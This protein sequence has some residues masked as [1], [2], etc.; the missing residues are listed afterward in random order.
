MIYIV[1]PV[2][3][4]RLTPLQLLG[5]SA[6]LCCGLA[7][8]PAA[9]SD[10]RMDYQQSAGANKPTHS[11]LIGHGKLLLRG[12]PAEAQA[13]LLYS[14][15][16]DHIQIIDHRKRTVMNLDEEQLERLRQQSETFKPLL[17]GLGAQLGKL[18]P[19]QKKRWQAMLG[20]DISLEQLSQAAKP[21]APVSLKKTEE[22]RRMDQLTCTVHR[23]DQG[24]SRMG[25]V[26]LAAPEK[27]S[28][29]GED[30]ATLQEFFRFA[31]QLAAEADGWADLL[32]I[33][34]PK[35]RLGALAAVPISLQDFSPKHLGSL[36]L[37]AVHH[38]AIPMVSFQ[39]PAGYG[40]QALGAVL[41]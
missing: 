12:D 37:L 18:T 36:D 38:E 17:S 39:L 25:E 13:D 22:V 7:M 3:H 1:K 11:L 27:L 14:A 8:S 31:D 40:E 15:H 10:I 23:L 28:M 6:C 32:K 24:G 33:K 21:M 26:C 35:I 41:K 20:K 9:R 34:L 2:I 29:S 5:V 16:P 19:E 30:F 4:S